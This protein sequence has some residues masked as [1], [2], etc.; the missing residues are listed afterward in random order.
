MSKVITMTVPDAIYDAL[1]EEGKPLDQAPGEVLKDGLMI[2][3][4]CDAGWML[5]LKLPPRAEDPR[6]TLLPLTPAIPTPSTTSETPA[7]AQ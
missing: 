4:K 6:Q 5:K 1:L 2:A 3:C 7:A